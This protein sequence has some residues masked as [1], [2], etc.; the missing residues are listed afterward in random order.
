[1]RKRRCLILA[2]GFYEWRQ[3]EGSKVPTYIR[4]KPGEPVAF[5]G[6]WASWKAPSGKFVRSCTIITTEPNFLMKPIHDRMPVILPEEAEALWL[7]PMTEDPQVLK[8]LLVP[9]PAESMEAYTVSTL[10][11]SSNAETPACIAPVA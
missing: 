7:D 3:I 9:F 11:N 10:V 6:L 8:P 1:M 4:L 2:D 5:A